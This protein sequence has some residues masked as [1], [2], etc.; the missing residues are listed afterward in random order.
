MKSQYLNTNDNITVST[1]LS[2]DMLVLYKHISGKNMI[3]QYNDIRFLYH[4]LSEIME[5]D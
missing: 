2:G 3:L 4:C 5:N 1:S